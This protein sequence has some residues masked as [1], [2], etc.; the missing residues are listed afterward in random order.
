VSLAPFQHKLLQLY[1]DQELQMASLYEKLA[2]SFP[3][4]ADQFL[5]LA[6]E[7][8]EHAGWIDHLENC[9]SSGTAAFSEGKTRTYT[10]TAL[11][12]YVKGIRDA[13]DAGTIDLPKALSLVV[14]TEKSFIE[15]HV[16]DRFAG[17][18]PEVE[19]ILRILDDTQRDHLVRIEQFARRVRSDLEK[20][21]RG[22]H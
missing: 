5:A 16:F 22:F 19:R 12:A 7:E 1:K 17:D 6:G 15:R 21:A 2:Q 14:D 3:T 4:Y 13:L 18:S 10:L 20:A 8:R 11:I 9:V